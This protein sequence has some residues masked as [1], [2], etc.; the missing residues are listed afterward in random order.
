M[1]VFLAN[2][3]FS[4]EKY[5]F[6]IARNKR[7]VTV[8]IGNFKYEAVDPWPTLPD[9]ATLIERPGVA[10]DSQDEIYTFSRNTDHSVMVFNRDGNVIDVWNNIFIPDRLTIGPDGNIY[11]GELPGMTQAD[12]TLPNHGHNIS[13]ISPSGEKLGRIVHPEEGEE[14]GKFIAP[15]SIGVDSHGDICW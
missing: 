12:P 9:G 5:I 2:V 8:G 10:V 1:T 15:H 14:P 4:V 13:I 3:M 7:S 11:I 6:T